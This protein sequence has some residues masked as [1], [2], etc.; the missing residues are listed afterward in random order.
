MSSSR[1]SSQAKGN[2]VR[3]RLATSSPTF[4][5]YGPRGRN[6]EPASP[7]VTRLSRATASVTR[8]RLGGRLAY[9]DLVDLRHIA[10]WGGDCW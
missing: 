7:S 4:L 1:Q 3:A 10:L 5:R 8:Y 9:A 2:S 6:P